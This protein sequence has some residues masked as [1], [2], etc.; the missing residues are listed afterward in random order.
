MNSKNNSSLRSIQSK[1]RNGTRIFSPET[2]PFLAAIAY[3][4]SDDPA[5]YEI[6][7]C[8]GSILS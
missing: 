7:F 8:A 3:Y 5:K 2:F 6:P 4:T 1:I